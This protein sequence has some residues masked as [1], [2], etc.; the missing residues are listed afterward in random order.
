MFEKYPPVEKPWAVYGSKNNFWGVGLIQPKPSLEGSLKS[1]KIP[2]HNSQ[3][4]TE[5]CLA[6]SEGNLLTHDYSMYLNQQN[7]K[8]QLF[9]TSQEA[10][11]YLFENQDDSKFKPKD[12][13]ETISRRVQT[14][15]PKSLQKEQIMYAC[16][17]FVACQNKL[18]SQSSPK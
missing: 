5:L 4:P 17:V 9:R 14:D 15:F 1:N 12:S 13:I 16:R 10:I 8:I 18:S 2:I 3:I 7:T 11:V 6:Y